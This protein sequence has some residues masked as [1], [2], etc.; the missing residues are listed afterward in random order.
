M[1]RMSALALLLAACASDG[2]KESLPG[3]TGSE[4]DTRSD[5]ATTDIA[6]NVPSDDPRCLVRCRA[7]V[8]DPSQVPACVADCDAHVAAAMSSLCASCLVD[9]AVGDACGPGDDGL[10]SYDAGGCGRAC[11]APV[12]EMVAFDVSPEDPRCVVLC[13]AADCEPVADCQDDCAARL[14]GVHALCGDCLVQTAS[15][16]TPGGGGVPTYDRATCEDVCLADLG[17]PIL[18]HMRAGLGSDASR[19]LRR[20]RP[21]RVTLAPAS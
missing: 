3:L 2:P 9:T 20:A 16:C 18:S 4:A 1:M 15:A 19:G 5:V 21:S 13:R 6:P 8:C 17:R 7:L 10:P 11:T 14:S 12:G